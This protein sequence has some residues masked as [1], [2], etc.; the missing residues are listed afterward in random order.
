MKCPFSNPVVLYSLTE[1]T[2]LTLPLALWI[3][4]IF[5]EH[6]HSSVCW[7]C[8][9]CWYGR[10]VYPS[11]GLPVSWQS[12]TRDRWSTNTTKSTG[13]LRGYIHLRHPPAWCVLLH[14]VENVSF[15]VIRVNWNFSIMSKYFCQ[16]SPLKD[17]IESKS[18]CVNN[19]LVQISCM[20]TVDYLYHTK[21]IYNLRPITAHISSIFVLK[22]VINPVQ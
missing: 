6:T 14:S 15:E 12:L 20:K 3:T 8:W 19:S 4:D 13:N 17:F 1:P 2:M 18:I 7:S 21:S 22:E 16:T 5:A 10:F 11:M 9:S